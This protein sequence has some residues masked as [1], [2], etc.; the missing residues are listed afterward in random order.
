[1]RGE[2]RGGQGG[3]EGF[4][5]FAV[6]FNDVHDQLLLQAFSIWVHLLKSLYWS[7]LCLILSNLKSGDK[8]KI[9]WQSYWIIS[10]IYT[11]VKAMCACYPFWT[12][13]AIYL[14]VMH[15]PCIHMKIY[16]WSLVYMVNLV[17][18]SLL[19]KSHSSA[20]IFCLIWINNIL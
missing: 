6:C 11:Q 14:E 20:L 9:I 18:F 10:C 8:E 12:H 2:E 5:N 4:Q 7:N 17:F 1:M 3:L 15:K 13:F 19:W 16:L